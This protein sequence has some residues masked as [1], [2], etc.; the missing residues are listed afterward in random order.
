MCLIMWYD[1]EKAMKEL[2]GLPDQIRKEH[3][4]RTAEQ[5]TTADEIADRIDAILTK[6]DIALPEL[7]QYPVARELAP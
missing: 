3:R 2:S 1:W 5:R 7:T 4:S 6:H